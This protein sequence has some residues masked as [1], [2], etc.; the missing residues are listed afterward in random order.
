MRARRAVSRS[1]PAHSTWKGVAPTTN[2]F[3]EV[4]TPQKPY[5]PDMS[6]WCRTDVGYHDQVTSLGD[7][8]DEDQ[9]DR[10]LELFGIG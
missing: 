8:Y 2:G 5:C 7:D 4:H 3:D 10:M 1:A 6:C 9:Y